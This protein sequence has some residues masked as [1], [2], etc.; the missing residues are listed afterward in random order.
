MAESS[1]AAEA[2]IAQLRAAAVRLRSQ[3]HAPA[4][5]AVSETDQLVAENA[6]A[7]GVATL[8]GEAL[9]EPAEQP[10]GRPTTAADLLITVDLV[11]RSLEQ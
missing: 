11:L 8:A 1:S 5:A 7:A 9:P 2:A 3:P 4:D 6:V 10:S